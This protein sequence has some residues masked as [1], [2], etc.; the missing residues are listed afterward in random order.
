MSRKFIVCLTLLVAVVVLGCSGEVGVPRSEIFGALRRL[1]GIR[2]RYGQDTDAE[3]SAGGEEPLDP[4][5]SQLPAAVVAP[6][7]P[8][9]SRRPGSRLRS[10]LHW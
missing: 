4:D 8:A 7:L 5:G 6:S 10:S 1:A 3:D 9:A 2:F